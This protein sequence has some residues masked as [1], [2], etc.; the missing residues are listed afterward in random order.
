M[1]AP[2]TDWLKIGDKIHL[3]VDADMRE[4]YSPNFLHEQEEAVIDDMDEEH[5]WVK[6]PLVDLN[7][8]KIYTSGSHRYR[9][10]DITIERKSP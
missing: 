9:W 8:N 6:F 3:R 7:T 2:L 10:I 4:C 5:I 1:T